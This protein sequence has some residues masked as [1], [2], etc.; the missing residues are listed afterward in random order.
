MQNLPQSW[1]WEF[2]I[3]DGKETYR[4]FNPG[5]KSQM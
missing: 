4:Q 3:V 2:K 5:G 1:V